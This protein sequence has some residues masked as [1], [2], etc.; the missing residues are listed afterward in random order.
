MDWNAYAATLT[1]M[2]RFLH[3]LD[4]MRK[5]LLELTYGITRAVFHIGMSR[6]VTEAI[7]RV[8]ETVRDLFY[9]LVML[10]Y[11]VNH[12]L[13]RA[14]QLRDQLNLTMYDLA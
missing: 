6:Q 11:E 14:D 2:S 8:E 7:E 5:V 13:M 3:T 4:D 12:Y 10:N 1:P 9:E